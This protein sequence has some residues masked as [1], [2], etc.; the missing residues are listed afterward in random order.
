MARTARHG[1]VSGAEVGHR[2][3]N[4]PS[5]EERRLEDSLGAPSRRILGAN[6]FDLKKS[7]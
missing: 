2:V 7:W 6:Y 4:D 3:A 1:A 5:V